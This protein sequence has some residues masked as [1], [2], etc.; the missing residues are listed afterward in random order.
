MYCREY[1]AALQWQDKV[2]LYTLGSDWQGGSRSHKY[3]Q[4]GTFFLLF[5]EGLFVCFSSQCCDALAYH[6]SESTSSLSAPLLCQ[7]VGQLSCCLCLSVCLPVHSL[8]LDHHVGLLVKTSAWREADLGSIPA[9]TLGIFPG[10]VIPVTHKLALQWLLCQTLGIIGS[11]L[12]LVDPV[13][14]YC[15]W[16]RW[17]VWSATS[18]SV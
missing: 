16:V 17:K 1:K 15:D 3:L 10:W 5:S 7:P 12:G 4:Q 2:W 8:W 18:V 6:C 11:S 14:V 13:S 9:Y